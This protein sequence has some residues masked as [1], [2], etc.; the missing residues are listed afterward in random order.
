MKRTLAVLLCAVLCIGVCSCSEEEKEPARTYEL[1]MITVSEDK[2][3]DDGDYVQSAWEGL[4]EYAEES[5]LTYKY[6]EPAKDSDSARMKQI[7]RAADS[8]ALIVV[9]AGG[10]FQ[11]VVAE[12]QEKYPD[13][14]CYLCIHGADYVLIA[15][16]SLLSGQRDGYLRTF[17]TILEPGPNRLLFLTLSKAADFALYLGL[18]KKMQAV[19]WLQRRYCVL[20]L[21][22]GAAAYVVMTVLL[23]LVRAESYA[24]LQSAVLLAWI[25][26]VICVIFVICIFVVMADYQRQKQRNAY[27]RTTNELMVE[28]Y[29]KLSKTQQT[30]R[31]QVHDFNHH[32]RVLKEFADSQSMEDVRSY[33]QTLLEAPSQSLALCASGNEVIDA[34]INCR[35]A[36]A[37]SNGIEFQYDAQYDPSFQVDPVDLCAILSNQLDNAFEACQ[38]IPQGERRAVRVRVWPQNGN[39]LFLQVANTVRENPFLKNPEL[40]SAKKDPYQ[41]HGLGLQNIKSTAERYGGDLKS[42]FQKGEFLS[43]VFLFCGPDSF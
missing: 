15:L 24:V 12:A 43:T 2:S 34:V 28:N 32:L 31:Q 39:M 41:L 19:A 11:Q 25:L 14:Y 36:D 5:G 22:L 9:C 37:R 26:L 38:Q 42:T 40:R 27:L 4:K 29:R 17:H 1:A 20:A 13:V 33:L 23:T 30:I 8:G 18:R 3:I 16:M 10:A 21:G 6:Y 7:D 35:A